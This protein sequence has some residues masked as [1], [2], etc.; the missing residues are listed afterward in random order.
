MPTATVGKRGAVVIPKPIRTQCKVEE[1]SE[2]EFSV[3][4][5]VM[6]VMPTTRKRTR[7]DENFDRMRESL[8][9]KGVT[10]EMALDALYELRRQGG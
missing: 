10:L 6:I 7:M 8:E 5:N 9:E 2:L 1:G 4:N 3:H